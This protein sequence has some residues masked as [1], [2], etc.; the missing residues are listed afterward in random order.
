MAKIGSYSSY[1][2]LPIRPR[3][4]SLGLVGGDLQLGFMSASRQSYRVEM[5]DDLVMPNWSL[6]TNNVMGTG[7]VVIV[8]DPTASAQTQRFYRVR[9]LP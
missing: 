1:V 6:L 9:Q 7:G 8:I 2:I 4:T 5:T 3:V